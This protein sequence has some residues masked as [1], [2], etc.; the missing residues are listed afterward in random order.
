M[1]RQDFW[2]ISAFYS[3][4]SIARQ[5]T[6]QQNNY[7]YTVGDRASGNYALNTTTGNKTDRTGKQFRRR[8]DAT[9]WAVQEFLA[10][11][12]ARS[13]VLPRSIE[14]LAHLTRQAFVAEDHGR[15]VGFAAIEFYSDSDLDRILRRIGVLADDKSHGGM[16]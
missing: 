4:V 9:K 8:I 15:V 13:E 2:G 12:V 11:F 5:P 14:E 1:R 7:F 10:P 6:P 3:R 16:Q